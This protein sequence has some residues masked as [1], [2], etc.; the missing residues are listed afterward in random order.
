MFAEK[1]R[2]ERK[3]AIVAFMNL[4]MKPGQIA[5]DY[6]IKVIGHISEAKINGVEINKET[7]I[8]IILNSF[9]D[10]FDKFW[11]DYELNRREYFQSSLMQELQMV[12][13]TLLNK[14]VEVNLMY[15]DIS[16]DKAKFNSKGKDKKPKNPKK[17]ILIQNKKKKTK[18]VSEA[19]GKCF[20]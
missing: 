3:E 18:K 5:K 2:Q 13:K 19:K 14:K 17:T 15:I 7:Q 12:E 8:D 1:S 11:L 20:N 6:M 9:T 4:K 10:T 16:R